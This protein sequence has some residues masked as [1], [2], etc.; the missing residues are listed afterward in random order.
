MKTL[1]ALLS[2]PFRFIFA[3]VVFI[4]IV[5]V[6]GFSAGVLSKKNKSTHKL[7]I[8]MKVVGEAFKDMLVFPFWP[9]IKL[10]RKR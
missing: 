3:V 8:Y 5:I 10:Y 4:L 6:G 1:T 7:I 9:L 2:I